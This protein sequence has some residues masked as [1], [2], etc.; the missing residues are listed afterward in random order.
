MES[1]ELYKLDQW[2]LIYK[3]RAVVTNIIEDQ[4]ILLNLLLLAQTPT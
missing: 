2:I 1:K 4:H 3:E